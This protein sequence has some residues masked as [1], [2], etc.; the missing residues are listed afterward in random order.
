M[1][2]KRRKT[3]K[4]TCGKNKDQDFKDTK[5]DNETKRS[6]KNTTRRIEKI[7]EKLATLKMR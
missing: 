2:I 4:T 6:W 3:I 5:K 1:V 7:L